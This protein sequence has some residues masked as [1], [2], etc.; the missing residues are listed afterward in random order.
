MP[1]PHFDI[2]I[3]QRSKRQSSVAAAAYQSGDRL[4]SEYDQKR[5]AFSDKRGIVYTEIMLPENAPPEYKNRNTLWNAVERIENQWN[6]QLARRFIMALPREIPREEQIRLMGEYCNSQFVSK[7]MIADFAIHDKGDGNPH[8]HILLTLRPMDEQGQWLLKCHKEYDLDED[9]E[10]IRLPG[11]SWKSHKVNTAD[12]NERKYGEIWRH[13]WEVV[14]NKYLEASGRTVRI[15][16]R[17][18]ERQG[19]PHAPQ[20]HLGPEATAMERRG[21]KTE[22]G[23]LNRQVITA[24][25]LF[26][27]IRNAIRSLQSWL[28]DLS[29]KIKAESSDINLEEQSLAE[30]LNAYMELRKEGRATWS[31]YGQNQGQIQDIKQMFHVVTVLSEQNI[32]SIPKLAKHLSETSIS[33]KNIRSKMKANDSRI[34]DIDAMLDAVKTKK[35]TKAVHDKYVSIGWKSK[36]EKFAEEHSEELAR[37]KKA[38]RTLKKLEVELPIDRKALTDERATLSKDNTMQMAELEKVSANLEDLKQIRWYIRQVL[39][40]ALPTIVNGKKS[41]KENLQAKLRKLEL[42]K[43]EKKSPQKKQNMEL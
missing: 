8:A 43:P 20:I 35:E 21:I 28:S 32:D 40:E 14:Q 31:A 9:G 24:N 4:F 15:D 25:K 29:E 5:K 23:N 6:S 16:M 39:P 2:K 13:E 19:N 12:W 38:D 33:A 26:D 34:A 7:G 37:Y 18:F 10:R 27:S 11:G 36:K 42:E 3:V 1:C 41:A 30:I 22:L 17:S